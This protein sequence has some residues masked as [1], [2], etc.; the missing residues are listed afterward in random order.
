MWT[1]LII[2]CH[3]PA[4]VKQE[5]IF[6]LEQSPILWYVVIWKTL[7]SLD[8]FNAEKK[9]NSLESLHV[10]SFLGDLWLLPPKRHVCQA[11]GNPPTIY[12]YCLQ[13]FIVS[14]STQ[15]HAVQQNFASTSRKL[16]ILA[17]IL[18]FPKIC[19]VCHT[20]YW[21]FVYKMK[22]LEYM[23][24]IWYNRQNDVLGFYISRC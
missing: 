17:K 23:M 8:L 22:L 16:K 5:H 6:N 2:F 18:K 20:E 21:P 1:K 15:T 24:I 12:L 13:A 4:Q 11:L 9:W 7:K 19:A 3:S 14:Q 10:F